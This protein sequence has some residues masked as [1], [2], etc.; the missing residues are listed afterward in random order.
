MESQKMD[1]QRFV[2]NIRAVCRE[3]NISISQV[4]QDLGWSSGLISRWTKTCPSFEKVAALVTYLG[5]PYERLLENGTSPPVGEKKPELA[6]RLASYTKS[7]SAVWQPCS[8]DEELRQLIS[9]LAE[10]GCLVDTALCYRYNEGFF[11]IIMAEEGQIY[12]PRLFIS[13]DIYTVPQREDADEK[14][15]GTILMYADREQYNSWRNSK[16]NRFR[17]SFLKE[18]SSD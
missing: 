13:S 17:E 4:E 5:I 16:I 10:E 15:L 2:Y 3:K 7:G 8:Q 18:I 14:S 12:S 6:K 1:N 11:F 9:P